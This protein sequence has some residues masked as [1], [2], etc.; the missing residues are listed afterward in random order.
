L[1]LTGYNR[2]PVITVP[3]GYNRVD[4]PVIT[5]LRSVTKPVITLNNIFPRR[6]SSQSWRWSSVP[7]LR[8]RCGPANCVRMPRCPCYLCRGCKRVRQTVTAHANRPLCPIT[9]LKVILAHFI[10]PG[11]NRLRIFIIFVDFGGCLPRHFTVLTGVT[12]GYNRTKTVIARQE[13]YHKQNSY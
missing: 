5:V 7:L 8:R 2:T 11:Y 4:E 6:E 10:M 13:I 12:F 1:I 3:I 9:L